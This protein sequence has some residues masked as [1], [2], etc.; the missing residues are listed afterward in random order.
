VLDPAQAPRSVTVADIF[1]SYSREDAATASRLAD[2]LGEMG[3]TVFWDQRIAA[4]A[5]WDQVIE[6]ELRS[7]GCV[8]VLWS[9]VS[10]QSQWVRTEA[11]FGLRAGRLVPVALDDT[12]PPLGFQLVETAQLRGWHGEVSHPEFRVLT[13]GISQ[14]VRAQAPAGV[15]TVPAETSAD[16]S[17]DTVATWT[18]GRRRLL[19]AAAVVALLGMVV[20]TPLLYQRFSGDELPRHARVTPGDVLLP[21]SDKTIDP[22]EVPKGTAGTPVVPGKPTGARRGARSDNSG[23]GANPNAG[24]GVGGRTIGSNDDKPNAAGADKSDV[25]GDKPNAGAEKPDPLGGRGLSDAPVAGGPSGG[26]REN[27]PDVDKAELELKQVRDV[28]LRFRDAYNSANLGAVRAVFPGVKP[29]IF[30]ESCNKRS[31]EIEN[32]MEISR[33]R[34]GVYFVKVSLTNT[35]AA[36]TRQKLAP[37]TTAD[38]FEVVHQAG[39][40]RISNWFTPVQ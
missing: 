6:R 5:S 31:I 27:K 20:A 38:T 18:R 26:G 24:A 1:L 33:L 40:W 11:N 16:G 7:S 9:A 12:E 2:R 21:R 13:D 10:V 34:E 17:P 29:N 22:D 36:A 14:L 35:C 30:S 28:I 32:D 8:V 19:M 25:G 23:P 4:G 15:A 37:W 39:V 3:W